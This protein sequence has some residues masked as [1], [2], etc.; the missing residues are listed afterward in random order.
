M[1]YAV[2]PANYQTCICGK[3]C[4]GRSAFRTHSRKCEAE[5]VRSAVFVYCVAEKLPQVSDATLLRNLD[6][7]RAAMA[8]LPYEHSAHGMVTVK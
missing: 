1:G 3:V 5:Q 6:Q 7:F 4:K 8:A 2:K